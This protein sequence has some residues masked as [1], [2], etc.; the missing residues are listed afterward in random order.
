MTWNGE[1][2]AYL[3]HLENGGK[4]TGYVSTAKTYL[5]ALGKRYTPE[6]YL[7]LTYDELDNWF[8]RLRKKGLTGKPLAESSLKTAFTHAR[9]CLRWLHFRAT[10]KLETPPNILGM[11]H[12][13][14][15][16]RVANPEDLL[17]DEDLE[18][19][20]AVLDAKWRC[21]LLL[22]RWSGGRP[23]EI[24]GIARKDA[25]VKRRDG[26]E[27]AVLTFRHTKNDRPRPV[28]VLKPAAVEALKVWLN[29]GLQGKL[30]FPSPRQ[31]DQPLKYRSFW[32]ALKTAAK[33]AGLEKNIFPYLARHTRAS[34]L[35]AAPSAIRDAALGFQT[36][37]MWKNYT[38]IKQADAMRDYLWDETEGAPLV[39]DEAM[40]ILK[41]VRDQLEALSSKDAALAEALKDILGSM[42]KFKMGQGARNPLA[43]T[44]AKLQKLIGALEAGG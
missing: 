41:G 26:K 3:A 36:P 38:H 20:L 8:G 4:A 2:A 13:K 33:R 19:L 30:L 25:V 10:G 40:A 7:A 22:L 28:P 43:N 17:T 18:K 11:R 12:G 35:Y 21:A 24:L 37:T 6:S 16:S 14:A 9:A 31:P 27:Y 32:K 44:Q 29:L 1:L 5:G 34:E 42:P 23:S 15:E 39:S